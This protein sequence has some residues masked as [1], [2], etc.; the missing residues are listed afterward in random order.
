MTAPAQLTVLLDQVVAGHLTPLPAT[1]TYRFRYADSW[2]G[3]PYAYPVSLA[4]SL[5]APE[6]E[7]P[8]VPR[9]LVG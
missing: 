2:L 7:G 8:S 9:W 5:F 3:D 6:Y 4:L 1:N